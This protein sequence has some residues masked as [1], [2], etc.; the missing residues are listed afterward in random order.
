M[1]VPFLKLLWEKE[2]SCLQ[3]EVAHWAVGSALL[4]IIRI[5]FKGQAWAHM[6][7]PTHISGLGSGSS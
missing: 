5:A 1:A 4:H 2:S 6:P 7:Q 3:L